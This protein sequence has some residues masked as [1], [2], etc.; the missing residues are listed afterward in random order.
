[1]SSIGY[2]LKSKENKQVSIY[3]YLRP[4]NS[5]VIS[6]RTGLTVNPSDWSKAKKRAKPKDP[7]LKSLNNKLDNIEGFIYEK[8]NE[9]FNSGVE[10]NNRWLLKKIEEYNNRTPIDDYSYMLSFLDHIILNLKYK[11]ANDG[12]Q[13]LKKSTIKGYNTFRNILAKYEDAINEKLKFKNLDKDIIDD[14]FKWMVE[15]MKYSNYM[16]NRIMKRLK[17]LIKEAGLN[18]IA[19]SVNPEIIGRDYSFKPDRIINVFSED[20]FNKIKSVKNLNPSLENTRKWILIGLKIGQRVSDLLSIKQEQ[21]RFD[22]DGNAL[23]DIKQQKTGANITVG[24]NDS[25]VV[26]ILKNKLPYYISHQK[27]NK[28]IKEV[29]KKS[30]VDEVVSGYKYNSTIHRKK[31]VKV[32]KYELMTS[33][34]LRRSFAT[35]YYNKGVSINNLMNI[36]G[37]KRESTFYEY[38][39]KDPKRDADAYNFLNAINE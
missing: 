25:E 18:K 19:V 11:R 17:Y 1:M 14:F 33:H 31:L 27:F 2:R 21:I 4:P 15:E 5:K 32:P 28:Y 7:I 29:C 10:F 23:I 22:K 35:F 37:H 36:T 13:G 20:D 34:D 39:G 8:L 9:E 12:S 6:T 3:V 16:V 30:G 24:V 38:I 26:S